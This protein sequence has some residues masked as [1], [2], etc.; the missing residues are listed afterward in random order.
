ML[1]LGGYY[2]GTR[3]ASESKTPVPTSKP[4][5]GTPEDFARA[6]KELKTL[7]SEETVTTVEDQLKAHGFSPNTHHPG[8][9]ADSD[10]HRLVG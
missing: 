2:V 6:I 4:V 7:F 3:L 5:Y 8:T 9:V 1:G 10:T